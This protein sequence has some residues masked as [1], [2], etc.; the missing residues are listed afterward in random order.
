MRQVTTP[1]QR[2]RRGTMA[3]SLAATRQPVRSCHGGL[4]GSVA[5]NACGR[6]GG[7][8]VT[9]IAG[10]LVT[11]PMIVVVCKAAGLY[12]RDELLLRTST[13]DKAP[14]IL[15]VASLYAIV[16]WLTDR[17]LL[18]DSFDKRQFLAL[19]ATLLVVILLGRKTARYIA[20]R[21]AEPERCLLLSGNR[22]TSN[23]S[24]LR[25]GSGARRLPTSP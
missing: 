14:G 23:A 17:I 18:A 16:V 19:W 11:V 20:R 21:I 12:G 3:L 2:L 13:L 1:R 9:D 4:R 8:T 7:G 6:N 10:L 15:T 25:S 24:R 5:R 22:Y